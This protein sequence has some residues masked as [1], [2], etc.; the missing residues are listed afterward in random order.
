MASA[1]RVGAK[2]E[3]VA[4]YYKNDLI[5]LANIRI[6]RMPI[7]K[8]GIAYINYGPLVR[9]D[10]SLNSH[11]LSLCL[12]AL[13]EEYVN[14]RKLLLRIK[15]LPD[16]FQSKQV[17]EE[18]F[19]QNNFIRNQNL[20]HNH[21]IIIDIEQSLDSIRKQFNQKWRNCLNSAERQNISILSGTSQELLEKF[22]SLYRQLRNRKKFNV[23]QD[24]VFFSR[25]QSTLDESEK[26]FISI[27]EVDAIP[28][29]GHVSSMLGNTC[30]YLLG[31]SNEKALK[32]K[33]SYLLQWHTILKAKE[34]G[35]CLYDL[36]GI[37]PKGNPGVYH[38]KKGMGGTEITSPDSY[39]YYPGCF[40]KTIIKI[41]ERI[42]RIQKYIK[43]NYLK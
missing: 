35:C 17:I 28:V 32:I 13:I 31:A 10:N 5:G 37:D 4:I 29:A 19:L 23:D 39:D 14:Q 30:V 20:K 7:I 15:P 24:E 18:A 41:S 9:N 3:H 36:G 8:T 38:F 16:I 22:N 43:V 21:T 11:Q 1:E 26:F 12:K 27:A 25:V 6:K 34:K 40:K 42:Y 2:S 33:A